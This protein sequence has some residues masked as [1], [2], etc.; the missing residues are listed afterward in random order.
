MNQP[1]TLSVL[2]PVFNERKTIREILRRV[3]AVD[4]PKQIVIVDDCSTD[5]TREFLHRLNQEEQLR[6]EFTSLSPSSPNCIEIYF[7]EKNQGKGAALRRAIELATGDVAVFQDADLEYD[8][9][10]YFKLLQ[11]SEERRVGK[12]CRL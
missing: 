2:I 4:L 12:E 8:P 1:W 3:C 7:Q 9:Q 6:R 5:G 11:R 10:D